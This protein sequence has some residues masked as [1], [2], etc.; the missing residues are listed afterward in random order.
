M[1]FGSTTF[2][3]SII[4][5]FLNLDKHIDKCL[6][7]VEYKEEKSL[8]DSNI[9]KIQKL[10]SEVKLDETNICNKN[11]QQDNIDIL[12]MSDFELDSEKISNIDSKN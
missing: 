3:I 4:A 6:I 1:G 12:K 2:L 7:S 11:N 9:F 10:D 8:E 5:K